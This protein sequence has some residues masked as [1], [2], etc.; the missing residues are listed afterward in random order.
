MAT[1]RRCMGLAPVAAAVP[2]ELRSRRKRWQ[3]SAAKPVSRRSSRTT[4]GGAEGE[5]SLRPGIVHGSGVP[6]GSS[7]DPVAR[8]LVLSRT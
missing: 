4:L 8:G 1:T 6:H 5:E 3:T 7:D 2:S